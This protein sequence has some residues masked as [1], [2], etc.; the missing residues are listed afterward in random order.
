MENERMPQPIV[1]PLSNLVAEKAARSANNPEYKDQ[2]LEVLERAKAGEFVLKLNGLQMVALLTI[3]FK[4]MSDALAE[5][6]QTYNLALT[7]LNAA[8]PVSIL[9]DDEFTNVYSASSTAALETARSIIQS[10]QLIP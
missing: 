10:V 7:L 8:I 5:D 6:G 4:G 1:S 2:W 3:Y 9:S